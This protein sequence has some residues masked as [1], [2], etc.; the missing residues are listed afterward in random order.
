MVFRET[1]VPEKERKQRGRQ[2][3]DAVLDE[4][5]KGRQREV[6]GVGPLAI[7]S[8]DTAEPSEGYCQL[9]Y[10]FQGACCLHFAAQWIGGDW[11]KM[12]TRR[13]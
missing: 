11:R 2:K 3:I 6:L 8:D 7:H 13:A 9:R 1:S 5:A 10:Q 12:E 4:Y